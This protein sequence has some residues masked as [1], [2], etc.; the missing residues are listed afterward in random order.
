[1]RSDP[2]QLTRSG[3]SWDDRTLVV[4]FVLGI[5]ATSALDALFVWGLESLLGS[6]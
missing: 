2:R 6:R 1:M 3:T 5:V 4:L